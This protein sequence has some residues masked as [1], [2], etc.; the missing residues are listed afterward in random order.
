MARRLADESRIQATVFSAVDAENG[1][2]GEGCLR[3]AAVPGR[4]V[5]ECRVAR[6]ARVAPGVRLDPCPEPES[7]A[8][9]LTTRALLPSARHGLG[10]V[11]ARWVAGSGHAISCGGQ[12]AAVRPGSPP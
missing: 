6:V 10:L 4:G 11:S 2:C 7:R 9:A 5:H 12:N 3:V 1:R 8:H